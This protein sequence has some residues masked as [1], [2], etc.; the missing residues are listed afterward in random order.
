MWWIGILIAALLILWIA[1]AAVYLV[2]RK[3]KNKNKCEGCPF[4]NTDQCDKK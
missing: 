2:R 1:A 3:K 4:R